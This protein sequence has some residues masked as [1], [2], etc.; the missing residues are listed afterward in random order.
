MNGD[1][2]NLLQG[3]AWRTGSL[4]PDGQHLVYAP[5]EGGRAG[6]FLKRSKR[7]AA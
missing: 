1:G 4:Y 2:G 3:V 6:I 7:R 5:G